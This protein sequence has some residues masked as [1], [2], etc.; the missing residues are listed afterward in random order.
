M[1]Y[2]DM[3]LTA[4]RQS[5]L[6]L[7]CRAE[8][9]CQNENKAVISADNEKARKYLELP[10]FCQLVSYGNNIV[11]SA[12]K[13]FLPFAE[14]YI[15]K[16]SMVHCFETPNLSVLNDELQKYNHRVCFMA[17]YYLP[18]PEIMKTIECSYELRVLNPKDFAEYYL[19][20]WSNALC[21]KRKQLD[22]MAAGAFDGERLIG[23]AGCSADCENMW[24]IGVDVLPEY[25]RQGIAAA[26]TSRL[27]FEIME[28]GKTPFYCAAWANI[29]SARNAIKCGF[30]PS[31]VELT[32]KKIG[33][34]DNMNKTQAH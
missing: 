30:K 28:R 14:E 13:S 2:R 22:M 34:V 21:S 19:P 12:D 27:A 3:L 26:V 24:Q 11:A 31:W 10:F 23:L 20:E 16:Y 33:F 17:E 1:T 5:A 8:D 4:M 32:A 6:E 15:N 7:N 9:F 25:R 29:K 18:D